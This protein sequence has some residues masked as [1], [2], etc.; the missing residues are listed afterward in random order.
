MILVGP[1]VLTGAICS[2]CG[3]LLGGTGALQ[4]SQ[5]QVDI[6]DVLHL[7]SI[8]V[9]VRSFLKACLAGVVKEMKTLSRKGRM[10]GVTETPGPR[11]GGSPE[12]RGE[13]R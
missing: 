12:R 4:D 1:D 13:R 2:P 3:I 10:A 9:L 6:A 5:L 11:G 7:G 8:Q